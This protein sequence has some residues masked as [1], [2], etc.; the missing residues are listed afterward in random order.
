MEILIVILNIVQIL[1]LIQICVNQVK[2]GELMADI[3][4]TIIKHMK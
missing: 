3:C 4:K 2:T 1:L